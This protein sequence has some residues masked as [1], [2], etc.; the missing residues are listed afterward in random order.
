MDMEKYVAELLKKEVAEIEVYNIAK[1][2]IREAISRDVQRS[3]KTIVEKEAKR[4]I[5]EEI[6]VIISNGEVE[7]NDGYHSAETY[8]NF[9][10]LFKKT[11]KDVL[12][13]SYSMENMIGNAIQK[14]VSEM[15][16]NQAQDIQDAIVDYVSKPLPEK[17]K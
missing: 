2:I 1:E 11:L 4:L 5:E 15:Y 10:T 14:K 9:E 12:K 17:K 16:G 13:K 3:L 7:V 6:Q 8:P